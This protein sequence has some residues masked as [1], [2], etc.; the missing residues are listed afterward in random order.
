VRSPAAVSTGKVSSLMQL[1]VAYPESV[2]SFWKSR[3]PVTW[4]WCNLAASQWKPYCESVN[5][6]CPVGLVNRQWDAVDWACVLCVRT[7]HGDRANRSANL[8][9]CACQFYISCSGFFF[10]KT[11]HHRDLSAPLQPRYGSLR[12]LGFPKLKSL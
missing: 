8:H 5:R 7:I 4:P 11:S 3:E 6:H 12:L 9:Q 1:Y 2:Q 10:V